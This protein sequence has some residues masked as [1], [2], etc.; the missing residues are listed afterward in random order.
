MEG[1]RGERI[2]ERILELNHLSR[3]TEKRRE[4]IECEIL[5]PSWNSNSYLSS[6]TER[7]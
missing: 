4:W 5:N 1:W 7:L 6:N 2:S 3:R